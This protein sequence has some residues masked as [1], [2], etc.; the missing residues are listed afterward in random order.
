MRSVKE[1]SEFSPYYFRKGAHGSGTKPIGTKTART[2][3]YLKENQ[4]P[5]SD[6]TYVFDH[7]L[8]Y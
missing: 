1:N 3:P 6:P 4:E 7:R 2:E 5:K 8:G